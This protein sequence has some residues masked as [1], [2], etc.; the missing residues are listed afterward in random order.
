VDLQDGRRHDDPLA[1]ASLR[2][3][4]HEFR[5]RTVYGDQGTSLLDWRSR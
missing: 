3:H 2:L 1:G 4:E 5:A